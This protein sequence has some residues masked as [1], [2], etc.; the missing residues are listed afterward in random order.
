MSIFIYYKI[1]ERVTKI[2]SKGC[3]TN[4]TKEKFF[5]KN[6]VFYGALKIKQN[7]YHILF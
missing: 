2:N 4:T 3:D 7:F 5:F 1:S 6:I